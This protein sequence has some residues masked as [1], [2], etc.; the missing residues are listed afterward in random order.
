M[1]VDRYLKFQTTCDNQIAILSFCH[2]AARLTK[3]T[4]SLR[5]IQL[6]R[7][8]PQRPSTS[9]VSFQMYNDNDKVAMMLLYTNLI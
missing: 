8:D 9:G 1:T 5:A 7:T 3:Q 4:L 6:A 2:I